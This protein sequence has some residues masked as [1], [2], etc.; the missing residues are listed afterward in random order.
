MILDLDQQ[1]KQKQQKKIYWTLSEFK[2]SA[3]KGI[4]K[5]TYR[6]REN[7]CKWC[8]LWGSSIQNIKNSYNLTAIG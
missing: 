1:H 4:M 6:M 8:I 7:I 5:K 2:A 3:S